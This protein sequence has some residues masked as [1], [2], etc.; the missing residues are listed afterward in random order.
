MS[1]QIANCTT[2]ANMFHILRRQIALPFRKPVIIMTPKS[3]LR[4]PDARSSF[5]ELLPNS[6]FRPVLGDEGNFKKVLICSG[7]VYYDLKQKRE[8]RGLQ[9]DVGLIRVEQLTPFPYHE[10]QTELA[11][12][13]DASIVWVQEEHKN[14]GPWSYVRPRMRHVSNGRPVTYAGRPSAASPATGS[15]YTYTQELKQMFEVAFK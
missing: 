10:L 13:P 6:N 2:P 14:Q 4:L 7:K 1:F 11:K 12:N 15:K 8:E 3:L 9:N 5:D